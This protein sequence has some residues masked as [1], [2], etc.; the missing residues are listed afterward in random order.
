M[1]NETLITLVVAGAG[2]ALGLLGLILAIAAK[3]SASQAVRDQEASQ[4]AAA[5]T[6]SAQ[7]M[8]DQ[9]LAGA[10]RVRSAM[11]EGVQRVK[12][13]LTSMLHAKKGNLNKDAAYKAVSDTGRVF[14]KLT[15]DH[16]PKLEGDEKTAML[17]ARDVAIEAAS[18]ARSLLEEVADPADLSSSQRA[19]L[20]RL[21]SELGEAQNVL[22]DRVQARLFKRV[23]EEGG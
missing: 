14:S 23:L 9:E 18:R 13:S 6:Q 17:R 12:D 3:L 21:R 10:I 16:A 2:V 8:K 22:R 11:L 4:Q 19:E 7:W 15:D 5:Q 1:G 20:M